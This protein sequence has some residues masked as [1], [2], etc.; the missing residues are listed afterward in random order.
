MTH[1]ETIHT[2]K[3]ARLTIETAVAPEDFEP[4]WDFES[5]Q[6]R[7]DLFNKI[8]NGDVAWFQVR[9]RVLLDHKFEIGAD[10]LGGCCYDT[11]E[12]FLHEAYWRDMVNGACKEARQY[13][14]KYRT[15]LIVRAA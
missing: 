13:L 15:P 4:D 5:E 7:Q 9:V 3:T 2:F 10:Y 11:A 1:F 8:N 12:E 6:D 14:T